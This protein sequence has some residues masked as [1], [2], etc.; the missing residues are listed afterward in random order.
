M[1]RKDIIQ[2][3]THAAHTTGPKAGRRKETDSH[4]QG[5]LPERA[6]PAVLRWKVLKHRQRPTITQQPTSVP[7][8]PE[9]P[10]YTP[11]APS[12]KSPFIHIDRV[13]NAIPVARDETLRLLTL[14]THHYKNVFDYD[15]MPWGVKPAM[16][17]LLYTEGIG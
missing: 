3:V 12:A 14:N 5:I 10:Q 17:E 4:A 6:L 8:R 11:P 1:P 9:F 7:W 16:A 13:F 2:F 15:M